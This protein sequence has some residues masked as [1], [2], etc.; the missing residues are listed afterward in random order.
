MKKQLIYFV[1]AVLCTAFVFTA[2]DNGNEPDSGKD[3][4]K[5][6]EKLLRKMKV[7][8]KYDDK[9]DNYTYDFTYDEQNRLTKYS[10]E[11][12]FISENDVE[13]VEVYAAFSYS[14]DEI[15]VSGQHVGDYYGKYS[16]TL[17]LNEDKNIESESWNLPNR[18]ASWE[19][20]YI[21][22][23]NN[24][25]EKAIP[26]WENT[27]IDYFV[28]EN[29]NVIQTIEIRNGEIYDITNFKYNKQS[30]AG[31]FDVNRLINPYGSFPLIS[32]LSNFYGSKSK[33]LISESGNSTLEYEFDENNYVIKC[34]ETI[35]RTETATFLFEYE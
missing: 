2:C 16:V 35:S 18:D 8:Y 29:G 32:Y 24:E 19:Y 9:H 4:D 11:A 7:N 17:K 3:G 31:N 28:W 34:I 23:S 25:L 10:F 20:T 22:N 12:P 15:K 33:N 21:Y 1:M 14:E 6:I 13:I 27:N 30:Y 26:T 5:T